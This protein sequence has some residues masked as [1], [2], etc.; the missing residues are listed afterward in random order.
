MNQRKA[1]ALTRNWLS[2]KN[3]RKIN[4]SI[5]YDKFSIIKENR[6]IDFNKVANIAQSWD[7][8]ISQAN[9]IIVNSNYEIIDGQHRYI[10]CQTLNKPIYYIIG[11]G[12]NINHAIEMNKRKSDWV[13][14]EFIISYA[15]R[16]NYNYVWINEFMIKNDLSIKGLVSLLDDTTNGIWALFK[17]GNYVLLDENKKNAIHNIKCIKDFEPFFPKWRLSWFMRAF[18]KLNKNSNYDHDYMISKLDWCRGLLH[19]ATSTNDYY[20]ML[21]NIYNYKTRSKNR[22]KIK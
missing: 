13:T 21:V 12:L 9:P 22:I 4:M 2:P 16:G 17:S 8:T 7:E 10:V 6:E 20:E 5:D 14:L 11:D 19:R 1:S 3:E 15:K 18:V